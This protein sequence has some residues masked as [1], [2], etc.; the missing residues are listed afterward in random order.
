MGWLKIYYA[1]KKNNY[2]KVSSLLIIFC[3]ISAI[4]LNF[5]GINCLNQ[6]N[7]AIKTHYAINNTSNKQNTP[8]N[9]NP[10]LQEP[11]KNAT[12]D[13]KFLN[14]TYELRKHCFIVTN[15][16]V[17]SLFGIIIG[18][19]LIAIWYSRFKGIWFNKSKKINK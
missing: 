4:I 18:F 14:D 1:V 10:I 5:E 17:Y 8:S 9:Q 19:I 6:I 3:S 7:T 2:L 15:L 16:Y 12:L 13:Q 11:L